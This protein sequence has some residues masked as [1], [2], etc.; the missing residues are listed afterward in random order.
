MVGFGGTR[1]KS[2]QENAHIPA[3]SGNPFLGPRLRQFSDLY[4]NHP[5]PREDRR[6]AQG[7]QHGDDRQA[8]ISDGRVRSQVLS[9]LCSPSLGVSKTECIS[10]GLGFPWA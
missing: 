10:P 7:T 6:H 1:I 9:G 3:R 2:V 8:L 5:V 4:E